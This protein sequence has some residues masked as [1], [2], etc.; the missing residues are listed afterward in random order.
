MRFMTSAPA[1]V[2]GDHMMANRLKRITHAAWT[3]SI[4]RFAKYRY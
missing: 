2:T 4:E 3:L 1:C